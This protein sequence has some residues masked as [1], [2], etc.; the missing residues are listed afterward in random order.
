MAKQTWIGSD[1]VKPVLLTKIPSN[2]DELYATKAEVE[3]A[4]DGEA[5][6][7]AKEQAQDSEHLQLRSEVINAR[8]GSQ[9]LGDKLSSQD[10]A[11]QQLLDEV[12]SA[13]KGEQSLETKQSAQDLAHNTLSQEV[14][15]GRSGHA[16]LRAKQDAQDSLVSNLTQAHN[17]FAGEVITARQGFASLTAKQTDQDNNHNSL[18]NEIIDARDSKATLLAKQQQQDSDHASL[19][20][21]V[22][23]ARDGELTLL[24]KEKAQDSAIAALVAGSGVKVSDSDQ[25]VGGLADKLLAGAHINFSLGNAGANETL[26]VNLAEHSHSASQVTGLPS[27]LDGK[28]DNLTFTTGL[29]ETSGVVTVQFGNTSGTACQGNDSR[30]SD[31]RVPLAHGNAQH[32][33]HYLAATDYA[34]STV[35]GTVKARLNGTTAYFTINGATA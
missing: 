19:A 23:A 10:S 5:T 20:N 25:V 16:S 24:A 7:L 21:E 18:L 17:T 33:I 9:T 11:H 31:A 22:T 35:G 6:L 30:L 15:N 26:T 4:R 1:R 12:V 34:T 2:T 3:E 27:L 8:L 29:T 32:S 14:S 28:Q 13:R